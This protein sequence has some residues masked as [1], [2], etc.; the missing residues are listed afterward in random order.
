MLDTAVTL[1]GV[2]IENALN[3]RVKVV[4][5]SETRSEPRYS[6]A[7]LLDPLFRLP[8]PVDRPVDNNYNPWAPLMAWIGKPRSGVKRYRYEKPV[9]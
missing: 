2:T 3:E 9:D 4:V 1:F 6:L 8:R 5:G 7:R